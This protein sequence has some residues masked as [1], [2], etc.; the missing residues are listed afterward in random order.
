MTDTNNL[1]P[2]PVLRLNPTTKPDQPEK[3]SDSSS[4]PRG[5]AMRLPTG[6]AALDQE[7]E[8]RWN[9]PDWKCP[10]CGWTNF[11]VRAKC[12]NCRYGHLKEKSHA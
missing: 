9:E 10:I 3:S 1:Q 7:E 6:D 12:R 8:R 2:A 5:S 4:A 11:S